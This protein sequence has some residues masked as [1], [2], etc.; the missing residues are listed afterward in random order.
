[1]NW[2]GAFFWRETVAPIPLLG[3]DADGA[4]AGRGIGAKGG[5]MDFQK[6]TRRFNLY[7]PQPDFVFFVSL[8]GRGLHR[9]DR[10]R[11][12]SRP[13]IPGDNRLYGD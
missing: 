13:K 12:W 9:T 6:L 10:H 7:V 8:T 2:L 11:R 1:M 3:S 5:L 4:M